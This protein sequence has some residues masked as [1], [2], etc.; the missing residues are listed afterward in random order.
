MIPNYLDY[1]ENLL[2]RLKSNKKLPL[3]ARIHEII[4]WLDLNN[5]L[6][7]I[8]ESCWKNEIDREI[9]YVLQAIINA[10]TN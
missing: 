6:R 5:E 2:G 8:R 4:E 10:C 9:T 7:Q 3:E 1:F